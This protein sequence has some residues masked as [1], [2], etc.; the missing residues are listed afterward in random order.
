MLSSLFLHLTRTF[1]STFSPSSSLS[2]TILAKR[3]CSPTPRSL[4]LPSSG[5]SA[6]PSSDDRNL[7]RRIN[8][9][10][11]ETSGE[12]SQISLINVLVG[13]PECAHA[14][15]SAVEQHERA[16]RAFSS[17]RSLRGSF[18]KRSRNATGSGREIIRLQRCFG[19]SQDGNGRSERQDCF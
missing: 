17:A 14:V 11:K 9:S 5:D 4:P 7:K 13:L 15:V 8:L 10:P 6:C 16:S 2:E 18:R 1:R 12:G 3:T 19:T